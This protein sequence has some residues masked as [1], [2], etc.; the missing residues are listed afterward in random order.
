MCVNEC[1][2]ANPPASIEHSERRRPLGDIEQSGVRVGQR[3]EAFQRHLG[4]CRIIALGLSSDLEA[5]VAFQH[6]VTGVVWFKELKDF[7][8]CIGPHKRWELIPDKGRP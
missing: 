5:M 3:Y 8:D 7:T 6:E 4:P 2:F 1:H